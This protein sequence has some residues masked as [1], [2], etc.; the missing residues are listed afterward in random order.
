MNDIISCDSWRNL[1]DFCY[2]CGN[3]N[4]TIIPK[5]IVP[6]N[7]SVV[8]CHC[9]ELQDFFQTIKESP[10]RYILISSLSDFGPVI[11][12]EQPVWQDMIKWLQMQI[13]PKLGYQGIN[14]PPRCDLKRCNLTD[15]YAIKCYSFTHSTFPEIPPNIIRWY[16]TNNLIKDKRIV[17]IPFGIGAGTSL[18]FEKITEEQRSKKRTK[19][20]YV[21]FSNNTLER[22]QL[23]Q[24]YLKNKFPNVT[25]IED[26]NLSKDQYIKDL[27]SHEFCLCPIGNGI[28]CY[29]M[30]ETIYCGCCPVIDL[31]PSLNDV[32]GPNIS[33]VNL[34]NFQTICNL[35]GIPTKFESK[36][37]K[38][39]LS[40]W[41]ADIEKSRS[42]L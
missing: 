29:R 41:V 15:K 24:Y 36:N 12:E 17:N 18:L 9:D 21:N 42:L 6:P 26:P 10:N 19:L 3:S 16:C 32:Y 33:L 13:S 4:N 35:S 22:W 20:L 1:A 37:N 34:F 2:H 28:D 38:S 25:V 5:G 39:Q 30:L 40:Y 8:H 27:L 23:K 14:L 11:Q 7:K 31:T